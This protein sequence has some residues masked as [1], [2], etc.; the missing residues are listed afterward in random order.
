MPKP[1]FVWS[2]SAWVSVATEVESLANYATVNYADTQPGMKLI[3]PSSISVGSGSST[4]SATGEVGFTGV[5]SVSLNS[6]FSS[7]YDNYR[8]IFQVSS[9]SGNP[10]ISFRMRTGTTDETG[11]NY[12]YSGIKTPSGGA[13]TLDAAVSTSSNKFVEN[14]SSYPYHI[15]GGL[16]LF[17]PFN[18]VTTK[19]TFNSYGS[20]TAG[21]YS[22]F[23]YY[24]AHSQAISYNGITFLPST[25]TMNGVVRVYGMKN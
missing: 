17:N 1:M 3:V 23:T 11:N 24:G 7:T 6:C 16:D 8:I 22:G 13:V 18:A 25:G 14:Y 15:S 9:T 21:A 19:F 12:S 20:N 4:L 10:N 5:S 2:G